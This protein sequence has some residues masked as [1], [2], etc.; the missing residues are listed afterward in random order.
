MTWHANL[1]LNYTRADQRVVQR[2]VHNGPLRVLQSLYPEGDA[3]CHTV[4]VHPPGGLV[5]GD[6]LDIHIHADAGCHALITTPGATRFY[7]S[8]GATALQRCAIRLEAGARL[9]WLPLEALCY[10]ECQA[11]N[12]LRMDLAPGA[13]MLGW[14]L[15]AI[16]LPQAKLPFVRGVFSQHIEVPGAW[17]ERARIDASDTRLLHSPLGLGGK[18]C[19]ASLFLVSGTPME[20]AR[21]DLALELA[22]AQI[23]Q[24]P[25]P[26]SAGVTS[27]DPRVV[28][29]RT[30]TPLVEP[31]MQLLRAVRSAWRQAL[32]RMPGENPR[33]WSM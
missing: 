26:H 10:N 5:G 24:Q 4:L 27:P 2:H 14:D 30:L 22:R 21:I 12:Q 1:E 28:V 17:L 7:R 6:T 8:T 18:H 31:A 32:W 20:R 29:L 11:D 3:V 13:E 16:G 9:E 33:L 23:D 15:T 25:D 19:I